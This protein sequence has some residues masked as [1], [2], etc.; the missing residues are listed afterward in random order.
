MEKGDKNN[1]IPLYVVYLTTLDRTTWVRWLSDD[2]SLSRPEF[3]P[4]S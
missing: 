2:F 3:N 4:G 1:L